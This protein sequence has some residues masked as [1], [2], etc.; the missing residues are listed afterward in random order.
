MPVVDPSLSFW[1]VFTCAGLFSP[2]RLCEP[3]PTDVIVDP[4]CGTGAIPI[5]VIT[6]FYFYISK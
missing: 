1:L 5:E 6:A 3:K 2:S 4:M